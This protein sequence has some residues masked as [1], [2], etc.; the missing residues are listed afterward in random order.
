ME[1]ISSIA[2]SNLIELI[3]YFVKLK[4]FHNVCSCAND[5]KLIKTSVSIDRHVFECSC[6]KIR[7]V[8]SGSWLERSHLSLVQVLT[9]INLWIDNCQMITIQRKKIRPCAKALNFSQDFVQRQKTF[10]NGN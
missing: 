6:E 10:A 8:R 1:N 3:N 5:M 7:S 4:V 9:F 2:N